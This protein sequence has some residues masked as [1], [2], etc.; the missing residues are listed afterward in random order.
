MAISGIPNRTLQEAKCLSDVTARVRN[1]FEWRGQPDGLA[2]ASVK[3]V[4]GTD[5]A[6]ALA[7]DSFDASECEQAMQEYL[8]DIPEVQLSG[9]DTAALVSHCHGVGVAFAY[10]G[11][12]EL[13]LCDR[14]SRVGPLK[15]INSRGD[16]EAAFFAAGAS[17]LTPWRALAVI[18]GARGLTNA[19]GAVADAR[20]SELATVC[21]VG[22]PSSGSAPFL[23]PHGEDGLL[24]AISHFTKGW[25]QAPPVS[26]DQSKRRDQAVAFVKA[27]QGAFADAATRPHGPRL[28]GIPQDVAET[29]WM[30]L[31]VV[32]EMLDVAPSPPRREPS[33]DVIEDA[34]A[35]IKEAARPV[36]LIDDYALRYPD[37]RSLLASLANLTG[38]PVLQVRYTRG[39]MMH[40]RLSTHDV[41]QFLGWYDPGRP[42]HIAVMEEAD[43]LVT[44]EDRNMYPRVLGPLPPCRKLAL[45]SDRS[46]VEKNKYLVDGDLA[47]EGDVDLTL[48]KILDQADSFT[49]RPPVE[50]GGRLREA[51]EVDGGSSERDGRSAAHAVR[52]GIGKAIGEALDL[53]PTPVLVDDSSMFG[54]LMADEY[55]S[56]PARTRVLGAHGGFVGSSAPLATGLAFGEPEAK[57]LCLTGDQGFT[58]SAQALVAAGE[59]GVGPVYVVANNGE[60]V[61]LL[62]QGT[63][64]D[65]TLFDYQ[66]FPHLGNGDAFSYTG[67]VTS[68]GVECTM[69]DLSDLSSPDKID[70]ELQRLKYQLIAGLREAAPRMIEL[71][72][73]GLSEFWSGIWEVAGREAVRVTA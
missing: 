33:S 29:P 26:D 16:K 30:D 45:T 39:P 37:I 72:L 32:A 3:L 10:A 71:R 25:W 14:L 38:A 46:K 15:L 9:A 59:C 66:A 17:L 41:P 60:A 22:L 58:N 64:Q 52:T 61:S 8:D 44:V 13:M 4:G 27:L 6:Q 35:L 70:A 54:G 48:K 5:L 19:C 73:P 24:Q 1:A 51:E 68:M 18:H 47:V 42:D 43:L 2:V 55:D 28:F 53:H 62:K 49:P 34:T 65:P 40:E 67:V 56:L 20:R 69:I 11:T 21:L 7:D 50:A 31:D 12:S 57:V 36:V 63:A 23:P